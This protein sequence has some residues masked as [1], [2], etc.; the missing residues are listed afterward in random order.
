MRKTLAI[1]I[2]LLLFSSCEN[3][4]ITKTDLTN[5][6]YYNIYDIE[7]IDKETLRCRYFCKTGFDYIY[8]NNKIVFRDTIGKYK[9]GDKV[10]AEF[11]KN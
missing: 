6:I 3:N 9:I 2:T 1:C 10:I 8:Y 7:S 5:E 4:I 11:I